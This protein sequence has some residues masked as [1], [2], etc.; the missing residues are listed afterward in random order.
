MVEVFHLILT[1]PPIS[2]NQPS[3]YVTA[4]RVSSGLKSLLVNLMFY[5]SRLSRTAQSR[6]AE[7][8]FEGGRSG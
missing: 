5:S 3:S 1:S 7:C 4:T 6:M 2:D 8:I